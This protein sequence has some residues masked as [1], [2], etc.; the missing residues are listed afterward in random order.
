MQAFFWA[1]AWSAEAAPDITSRAADAAVII[2]LIIFFNLRR[3]QVG[4]DYNF[5]FAILRKNAPHASRRLGYLL[6]NPMKHCYS[7]SISSR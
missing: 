1:R 7:R 6:P 4:A 3:G 2:S 5:T